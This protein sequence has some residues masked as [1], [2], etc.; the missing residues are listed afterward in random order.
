MSGCREVNV[1]AFPLS[2]T[3]LEVRRSDTV[4]DEF[5]ESA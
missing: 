1:V 5:R 4:D 2:D 3:S